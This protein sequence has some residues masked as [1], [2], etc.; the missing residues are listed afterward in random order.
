MSLQEDKLRQSYI[1]WVNTEYQLNRGWFVTCHLDDYLGLDIVR[2]RRNSS[3]TEY[4]N[5]NTDRNEL[6]RRISKV[7]TKFYR[8]LE[9]NCFRK[10][11][12]R[13]EKFSVIEMK[14][15][16]HIHYVVESCEH[17]SKD[18]MKNY[19]LLSYGETKRLVD[20]NIKEVEYKTSLYEYM[21]K[22]QVD[23]N[24]DTVDIE[25]CYFKKLK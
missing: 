15:R 7:N 17:L 23:V 25:N 12:K 20:F 1:D 16:N 14:N 4:K 24:K 3:K 13:L 6:F 19:L 5:L 18:M 21:T 22:E 9:K 10:D 8:T 2:V 11:R